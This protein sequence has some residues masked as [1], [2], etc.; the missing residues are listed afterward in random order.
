VSVPPSGIII[1]IIIIITTHGTIIIHF[2]GKGQSL[3]FEYETLCAM[4]EE[5]E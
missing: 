4:G 5:A 2:C 3:I 1:I